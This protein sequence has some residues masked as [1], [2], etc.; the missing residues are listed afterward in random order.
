[1]ADAGLPKD[2]NEKTIADSARGILDQ[3]QVD[4]KE[5]TLT[6]DRPSE[7]QVIF[8]NG[9]TGSVQLELS[10][11]GIPGF[12][13]KLEQEVVRAAADAHVV[14]RYE[15]GDHAA[16]RDPVNVQITVQPL[17]QVFVIRVSFASK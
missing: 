17:N 16:R 8:H 6:T 1:N 10:A 2:L 15:P 12:S 3:V 14:F 13:A 11:P 9:L 4:K 7:A 5:I